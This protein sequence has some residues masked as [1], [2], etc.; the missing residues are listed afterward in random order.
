MVGSE[1]RFTHTPRKTSELKKVKTLIAVVS[2]FLLIALLLCVDSQRC[3][4]GCSSR[5]IE[6]GT[7]LIGTRMIA[8]DVRVGNLYGT[9]NQ[10][11]WHSTW[12]LSSEEPKNLVRRLDERAIEFRKTHHT[13]DYHVTVVDHNNK[14][15]PIEP[16][17]SFI[18]LEVVCGR[19]TR[20]YEIFD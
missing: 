1:N 14:L 19:P 10:V 15:F 3:S 17:R 11:N 5:F 13:F 7:L 16:P 6:S 20:W 4:G 18:I 2:G 9:S 12:L 8:H